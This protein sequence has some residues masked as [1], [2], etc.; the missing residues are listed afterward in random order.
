MGLHPSLHKRRRYQE[1]F[2][3][4]ILSDRSEKVRQEDRDL[5]Q[6]LQRAAPWIRSLSVHEHHSSYQLMLGEHCIKLESLLIKGPHYNDRFEV[7]YW[8]SCRKLVQ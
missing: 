6:V 7:D 8:S 4:F 1:P 5:K 3:R 2:A